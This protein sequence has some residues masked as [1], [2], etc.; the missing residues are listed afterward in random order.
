MPSK[1][2]ARI[3]KTIIVTRHYSFL[4][5]AIGL[6]WVLGPS[7]VRSH[8]LMG[9]TI[10]SGG[11]GQRHLKNI[12]YS[13][14]SELWFQVDGPPPGGEWQVHEKWIGVHLGGIPDRGESLKETPVPPG[15]LKQINDRFSKG[16]LLLCDTHKITGSGKNVIYT[17]RSVKVFCSDGSYVPGLVEVNFERPHKSS[18]P[19]KC[20]QI[21]RI[22]IVAR[23]DN[24]KRDCFG[25]KII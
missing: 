11:R 6:F 24:S 15:K 12:K 25:L 18:A 22:Y 14:F 19:C 10:A 7:I 5:F 9:F 21:V 2:K 4:L 17:F 13:L 20:R 23:V 8:V 3:D 1:K 16:T